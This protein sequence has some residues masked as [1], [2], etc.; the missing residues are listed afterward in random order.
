MLANRVVVPLHWQIKNGPTLHFHCVV[1]RW[2]QNH[3]Y[4]AIDWHPADA[5]TWVW[6]DER[7]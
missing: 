2:E 4:W 7:Q 1:A 5:A 3:P 6:L